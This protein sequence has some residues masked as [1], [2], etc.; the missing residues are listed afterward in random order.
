MRRSLILCPIILDNSFLPR[1]LYK[2]PTE[3]QR[4]QKTRVSLFP[5]TQISLL[6]LY[7][8][9]RTLPAIG[10]QPPVATL[11]SKMQFPF[12]R[13]P[14]HSTNALFPAC[15]VSFSVVPETLGILCLFLSQTLASESRE[16]EALRAV[17]LP[18][19]TVT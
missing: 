18:A 10:R 1:P 12:K 11:V 9:H 7:P 4:S 8:P 2:I 15:L 17:A 5:F 3:P 6:L 13:T 19:S 14:L 16:K